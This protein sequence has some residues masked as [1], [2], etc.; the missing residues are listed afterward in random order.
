M[1]VSSSVFLIPSICP[2]MAL[3][4]SVVLSSSASSAVSSAAPLLVSSCC[5]ATAASMVCFSTVMASNRRE[6]SSV[7]IPIRATFW[8]ISFRSARFVSTSSVIRLT[9]ASMVAASLWSSPSLARTRKSSSSTAA[10]NPRTACFLIEPPVIAPLFSIMFAFEG[11]HPVFADQFP[12][13]L[14]R[15]DHDG[16]TECDGERPVV[17]RVVLDQVRCIVDD[18]RLLERG[19]CRGFELV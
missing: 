9:P 13:P 2:L 3:I 1:F 15:V 14:K 16:P 11:H 7:N 18:A 10:P 6:N 4:S 8:S 12:C 5:R 19:K 17:L